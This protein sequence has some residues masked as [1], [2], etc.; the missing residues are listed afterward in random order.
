MN[1]G[2]PQFA[3]SLS[4]MTWKLN[5]QEPEK[6][7]NHQVLLIINSPSKKHHVLRNVYN[8]KSFK[9]KH[10]F[11]Q[12]IGAEKS[13]KSLIWIMLYNINRKDQAF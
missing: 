3:I 9:L 4:Q 8:E 2:K 13:S 5:I 10:D 12:P 11:A 1:Q 6:Q 7:N